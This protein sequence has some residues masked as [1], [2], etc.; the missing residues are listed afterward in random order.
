M[1][2]TRLSSAGWRP[3]PGHELTVDLQTTH[4]D[5]LEAGQAAVARAEVV[6]RELY[7]EEAEAAER[8]SGDF[9]SS[10][11]AVSVI[12]SHSADGGEVVSLERFGDD[13]DDVAAKSVAVATG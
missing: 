2:F 1:Q 5:E 8:G 9:V 11:I 3:E 12:S 7:P 10:V 6:Q 13:V 4:G